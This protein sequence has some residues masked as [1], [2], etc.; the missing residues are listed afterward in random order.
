MS[1]PISSGLLD[2]VVLSVLEQ[3]DTYGYRITHQVRSR[4]DISE[5]TLYPVL[6]RLEKNDYLSVYDRAIDGRNRRYYTLTP[7]GRQQLE[8]YRRDWHAYRTGIESLLFPG[9]ADR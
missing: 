6:R 8:Q 2:A 9:G 4:L 3:G 5:S 7:A 1:F